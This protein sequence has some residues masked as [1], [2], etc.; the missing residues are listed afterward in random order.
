MV[1]VSLFLTYVPVVDSEFRQPA[2]F[3]YL[4]SPQESVFVF[5]C[6]AEGNVRS[7]L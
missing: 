6:N 4:K 1:S 5:Y 3:A 7:F 2:V